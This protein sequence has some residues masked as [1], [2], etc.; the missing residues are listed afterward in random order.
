MCVEFFPRASALLGLANKV[1]NKRDTVP[2]PPGEEIL[3]HPSYSSWEAGRWAPEEAGIGRGLWLQPLKGHSP[4]TVTTLALVDL[5]GEFEGKDGGQREGRKED[6]GKSQVERS[7]G[8]RGW[9]R[10]R[11]RWVLVRAPGILG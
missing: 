3:P 8:F 2:C 9:G 1:M 5:I 7:C 6:L 10:S 11:V 4:E